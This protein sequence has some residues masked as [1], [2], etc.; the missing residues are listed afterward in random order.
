ML[1][2]NVQHSPYH[3]FFIYPD[4]H[5]KDLRS[6][7][8]LEFY[9]A[10]QRVAHAIRPGRQGQDKEV[11][12]IVANVDCILYQALFMVSRKPSEVH[13][14]ESVLIASLTTEAGKDKYCMSTTAKEH[15]WER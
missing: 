13:N 1:E 9:R 4:E 7:S 15:T 5:S 10:S 12:G 14:N 3:S 6:I 2:H 11:V 8:N